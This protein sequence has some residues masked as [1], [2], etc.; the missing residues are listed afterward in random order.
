MLTTLVSCGRALED[1]V[2]ENGAVGVAN[3]GYIYQSGAEI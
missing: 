2:Q 1:Y 3:I